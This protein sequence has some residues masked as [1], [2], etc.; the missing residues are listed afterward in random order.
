MAAGVQPPK[1]TI[2]HADVGVERE[3][4]VNNCDLTLVFL[5]L[6]QWEC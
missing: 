2:G 5:A 3:S 4:L 6:D 1:Q